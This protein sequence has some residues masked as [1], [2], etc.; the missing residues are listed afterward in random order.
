MFFGAQ[1]LSMPLGGLLGSYGVR[2]LGVPHVFAIPSLLCVLSVG[3]LVAVHRQF[4]REQPLSTSSGGGA[5]ST[6]R[7]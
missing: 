7:P 2:L 1:G 3:V 6:R 4:V 5:A